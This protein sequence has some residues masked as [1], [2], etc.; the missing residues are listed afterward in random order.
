MQ[1]PYI[2]RGK[3]GLPLQILDFLHKSEKPPFSRGGW[4]DLTVIVQEVYYMYGYFA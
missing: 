1:R 4:G 3:G 2:D